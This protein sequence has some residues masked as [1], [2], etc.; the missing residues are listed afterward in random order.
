MPKISQLT[1][2]SNITSDDLFVVVNDP[3]GTPATRKVTAQGLLNFVDSGLGVMSV[4]KG[5]TGA[6]ALTGYVKGNGTSAFTASSTIPGSDVSGNI[7]GSSANVTGVVAIANGGT[8][9]T[10]LTGIASSL[11][12][13]T[14]A[15][16]NMDNVTITGGTISISGLFNAGLSLTTNSFSTAK[17]SARSPITSF[18]T[19]DDTPIFTVP[20]GYMFM[21][22]T[23]EIVTTTISGAGVAPKVRFG[24]SG[25]E[26][27]FYV[28][29]R[30][31]SNSFGGRHVIENPQNGVDAGSVVTFG[32]AEASTATSHNGAAVVTGYLLKK[33]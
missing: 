20:S 10:S 15:S 19:V 7:S 28:A 14:L 22:D 33:T 17:L 25:S 18:K 6:T 23:M 30:T 21:V 12:F 11:G 2:V 32:I 13:G 26:D 8:G 4:T 1:A 29:N 16:Q 24:I 5:G 31:T 3:S 9:E 27:M